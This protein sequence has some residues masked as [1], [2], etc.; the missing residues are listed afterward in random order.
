MQTNEI[1]KRSFQPRKLSTWL[2]PRLRRDIHEDKCHSNKKRIELKLHYEVCEE[3]R[4][5]DE[6]SEDDKVYT[7]RE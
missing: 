3:K 5:M 7:S 4:E 2:Q 6:D 1:M